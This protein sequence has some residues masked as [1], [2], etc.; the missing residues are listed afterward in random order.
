MEPEPAGNHIR[1]RRIWDYVNLRTELSL[2]EQAHL[3]S[4]AVCLAAFR[5]CILSDR[6]PEH[7]AHRE[8]T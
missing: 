1:V 6:P 2:E 4:C 8:S 5:V 3:C 7:D